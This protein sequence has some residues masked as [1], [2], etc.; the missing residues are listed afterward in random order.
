MFCSIT[1]NGLGQ[2]LNTNADTIA[3]QLSKALS[4]QYQVRLCLCLDK[5]GV[6][7]EEA[8]LIPRLDQQLYR[9]LKTQAI[10]RDGMI[11]KL[12]NAFSVVEKSSA[13][14]FICGLNDLVKGGGTKVILA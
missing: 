5:G 1:H 12:D 9:E 3:A 7:N 4:N 13:D 14:V 11:P 6:L 10:I 2:L 8:A